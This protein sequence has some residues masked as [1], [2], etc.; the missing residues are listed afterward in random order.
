MLYLLLYV[1]ISQEP[2]IHYNQLPGYEDFQAAVELVEVTSQTFIVVHEEC[3]PQFIER[4]FLTARAL[5]PGTRKPKQQFRAEMHFVENILMQVWGTKLLYLE[6]RATDRLFYEN[7]QTSLT[8]Q[9][10]IL[11]TNQEK[12]ENFRWVKSMPQD[13]SWQGLIV[14]LQ[15][16]KNGIIYFGRR[17]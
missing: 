10:I 11:F 7:L 4:I 2:V 3:L 15:S 16:K 9:K 17:S 1:F 5:L 14:V 6:K 12:I 13:R 8:K